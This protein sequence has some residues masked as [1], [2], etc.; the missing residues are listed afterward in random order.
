MVMERKDRF[1]ELGDLVKI[2]EGTHQ[3]SMPECRTGLVVERVANSV[4]RICFTNGQILKFHR[5]FIE[6]INRSK[7]G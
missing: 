7:N 5:M 2:T 4:Y 6:I 1:L 3:E